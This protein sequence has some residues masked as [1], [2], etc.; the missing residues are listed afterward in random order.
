MNESIEKI[1][2]IDK[3]EKKS[4]DVETQPIESV[5]EKRGT[6]DTQRF[7]SLM[8]QQKAQEV[9]Q[10][11]QTQ[12]ETKVTP[13]E[14]SSKSQNRTDYSTNVSPLEIID[15][16]KQIIAQ[17]DQIKSTLST[18]NLQL[19]NSV[20]DVLRNKLT[21]ID[22][23]IKIALTKAGGEYQ[24]SPSQTGVTNPIEKFLGLLTHGQS[25]LVSLN[26]DIAALQGGNNLS[27]GAML[28]LQIKVGHI[29]QEIE[30]FASCLNKSLE[31]FKTLMNV[32]V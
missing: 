29:Q 26:A 5:E 13:I 8:Q 27:P 16:T 21:H 17:I 7:D 11:Q 2:K 22:E 6:A 10:Q 32:Q 30:F 15:D 23:N 3:I 14:E 28:A 4:L 19:K 31:S 18:P 25:Q 20:Q 9:A 1:E 24:E 12:Q